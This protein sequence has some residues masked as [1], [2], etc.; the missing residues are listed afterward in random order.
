MFR[1][2]VLALLHSMGIPVGPTECH[3]AAIVH[4]LLD[5]V[6]RDPFAALWGLEGE[7][8]VRGY[9]DCLPQAIREVT[10]PFLH[11]FDSPQSG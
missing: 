5:D 10:M 11:L 9:V 3:G 8:F 2:V 4:E 7:D 6:E 1:V